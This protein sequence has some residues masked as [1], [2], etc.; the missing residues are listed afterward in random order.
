MNES[1][2]FAKYIYSTFFKICIIKLLMK[3]KARNMYL[4]GIKSFM[5][6]FYFLFIY[7]NYPTIQIF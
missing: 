4:T 1:K 3:Y 7:E 2:N 5:Y 6:D